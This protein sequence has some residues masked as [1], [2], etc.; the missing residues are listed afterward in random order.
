MPMNLKFSS[1]HNSKYFAWLHKKLIFVFL[2]FCRS[3][4]YMCVYYKFYL[5]KKKRKILKTVGYSVGGSFKAPHTPP[6]FR[7]LSSPQFSVSLLSFISSTSFD[8]Q[9][10]LT[11]LR[12]KTPE[13]YFFQFFRF[14]CIHLTWVHCGVEQSILD[15][16]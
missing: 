7:N 13:E 12:S 15:V 11:I 16:C 8:Q 1:L 6:P 3:L 4:K 5:K 14:A 2:N 10:N 9:I